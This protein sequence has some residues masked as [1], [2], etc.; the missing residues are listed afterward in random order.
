M[1]AAS[2]ASP[3]P[4]Q[5]AA[6]AAASPLTG[7]RVAY[8]PLS[9]SLE[10]PGDRRRFVYYA[11]RRGID[12]EIADPAQDYDVVVVSQ[13][14]DI[15]RWAGHRGRTRLVYDLID[16]YLAGP[17]RDWKSRGRGLAKF[18]IREIERPVA[19]YRDAIKAMCARADAIVCSTIRQ[20]H[21]IERF[22]GN[23]HVVLDA[24][25][26]LGDVVKSRHD[27]TRALNLL[28]EGQGE[29]IPA[30]GV[31]ADALCGSAVGERAVV[32]LFTDL[33]YF[34]WLRRVGR[35]SSVK[36]GRSMFERV[37]FYEWNPYLFASVAAGC[38]LALV[39]VDLTTPLTAGKPENKLLLFWR[40]GVPALVS[41]TDA[42]RRVMKEVGL[43]GMTARSADDWRLALERYGPDPEAR[44]MA[45]ERGLRYVHDHHSEEQLL[46]RWDRV[47]ASVLP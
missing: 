43:E 15:V 20:K 39:P 34:R 44:R 26:E 11:Q 5:P 30:L 32:H 23:V 29:N 7:L 16:A 12:F 35:R 47:F 14:A 1:M 17:A 6:A 24:H 13:R 45:A 9:D 3:R 25:F 22:S 40:L 42:H 28:W 18:A 27:A 4:V 37:Y 10:Q 46:A 41:A 33:E 19:D 8:A 36:L 2:M 21:D 38:D 31:V